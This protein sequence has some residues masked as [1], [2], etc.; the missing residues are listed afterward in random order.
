MTRSQFLDD[1]ST[2]RAG[3]LPLGVIDVKAGDDD[4]EVKFAFVGHPAPFTNGPVTVTASI[5]DLGTYPKSH[6]YFIFCGDNAPRDM[7]DTLAPVGG[8]NKKI[9]KKPVLEMLCIMSAALRRAQPDRDGDL[10]MLSEEDEDEAEH[11]EEDD[12]AEEEE[13]DDGNED[14]DSGHGLL[15]AHT[16]NNEPRLATRAAM[17]ST[18]STSDR[19][20]RQRI[21]SDLRSVKSAGFRVGQLG[22]LLTAGSGY[23]VV[24]IRIAKLGISEEAMQAW[25]VQST[26]YLTLLIQYRN[27]YKTNEQI[28]SMDSARLLPNVG[29]R[30][31][32]GKLPKPT[33]QE[34]IDVFTSARNEKHHSRTDGPA[35]GDANNE[36]S[37]IR[38]SFISKPLDALLDDRLVTILRF[39]SLGMSRHGAEEHFLACR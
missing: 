30:I 39:R 5:Q 16:V 17:F 33:L 10:Q 13:D 25:Q 29:I 23:V 1:I 22:H 7:S 34:V 26:E 12:D 2:A 24:S 37:S 6:E 19:A 11:D 9:N 3:P 28:S 15:V 4:G 14:D 20:F 32:I 8:I 36:A 38:G 27:G 31:V 35:V 18:R 21:R